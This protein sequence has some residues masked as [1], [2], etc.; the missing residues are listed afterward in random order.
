ME[1]EYYWIL[2]EKVWDEWDLTIT[3]LV[4]K[5]TDWCY[6]ISHEKMKELVTFS[7]N[8]EILNNL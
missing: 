7:W 1:K 2:V 4:P 5:W 8:M 6:S 3:R